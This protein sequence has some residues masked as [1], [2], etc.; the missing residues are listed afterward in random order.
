MAEQYIHP[1]EDNWLLDD[2]A[3]QEAQ[4]S[5]NPP[6]QPW[7][8]LIVDDEK[9]VHTATRLA[10]QDIRYK[11]RGLA[12]LYA[13]SAQ[14][15]FEAIAAHPDTA[16]ILLDVV[17]ETDDAGLRLVHRIRNE[18][19]NQS[20][21]IVLRTGQP[22]QAPEQEVILDYDINDYKTKTEL[23]VQKLFT[24]VIS[25]LR[26]HE[27]LLTIEKNRQGLAKIL[28]G[29]GDLYQLHSLKEFA[30]G[31]LKQVGTLL[32][33][34]MDGILCVE[35][36]TQTGRQK[37]EALAATGSYEEL[38]HTS[39]FSSLGELSAIIQEAFREKKSIYRHPYD[40]LYI[41][42]QNG[43][44]FVVHFSPPWPLEDLE[45]NLLEVFCQRISAAYDNLH[46][47]SQLLRSQEAT[48]VALADL[49]EFRDSDTGQH[50]L[51]VQKLVDALAHELRKMQ[52]YHQDLSNEFMERIGMASILHDVG[53]VG[54]PD[55]ILFKPGKLDPD[56]RTVMEQHA[57]IGANILQKA[58]A[59]VEGTSY[60]TLGAQIA[61]GHHEHYDGHGYP[62]NL[63]GESIP[64]AARI[65]AVVDV[66]DALL[67]KR[68]YKE[69]WS[70]TE[71][72]EYIRAR[73]G[74]QFD[75]QVVTAL[76][77]LIEEKRLPF[78]L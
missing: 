35:I 11:D 60:L 17:M 38:T 66:F 42:S 26:A 44:E 16:L 78:E 55:N 64:L 37:L 36:G 34:G 39:D 15:G 30:S 71:T 68:P 23:T 51:R 8:I 72:L 9:D 45:R 6:K 76:L 40:V 70:L 4:D 2:D 32:D 77:T 12:L 20:V 50:V 33:V 24:T 18:L 74:S 14:E 73:A 54:T 61:A 48:V 75:P 3:E 13:T 53:K 19:N 49:A 58:S 27:N 1:D 28:E 52:V 69:P 29:A 63:Q 46:L 21:R 41:K 62:N 47:Y 65:V 22:G 43:R 5:G 57:L 10:I 31:V 56:E 7:K 67:N 59:M 25:S